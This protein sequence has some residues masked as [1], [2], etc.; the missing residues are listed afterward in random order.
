MESLKMPI[1]ASLKKAL[2]HSKNTF[3]WTVKAPDGAETADSPAFVSA[4]QKEQFAAVELVRDV[5]G[6]T[7]SLRDKAKSYLPQFPREADG[8]WEDRR[9]TSVVYN[10]LKR[11]VRGL[12]GMVFRRD[13]V[14]GDDVPE[15]IREHLEDIDLQGRALHVFARDVFEDAMID[16]HAFVFIDWNATPE[17]EF[18]TRAEER[19]FGSRPYWG[20]VRKTDLLSFRR[21]VID[22]RP[23][24]TQAAWREDAIEAEGRFGETCVP[25]IRVN[26]LVATDAGR[27]VEWENWRREKDTWVMDQSGVLTLDEIPLI[28]LYVNRVDYLVSEPPLL[29]LAYENILHWQTRSDRQNTLHIAGVP[30][31]IFVGLSDNDASVTVGSTMGVRLPEGGE[32][33]YLEPKGVALQ[34]SREEIHDIERRMAMLGLSML[35]SD[36]RAAETATSKRIDK[37]ESDSQLAAAARGLEDALEECLRIHAKWMGLEQ[38]GSVAV[39]ADFV[40]TPMDPQ[41]ADTLSRLV[42]SGQLS[43]ETMWQALVRGEILPDSFDPDLERVRIEDLGSIERLLGSGN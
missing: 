34:E 24:L 40:D 11:T 10:A 2:E 28:P 8:S 7:P 20:L 14:I 26:R 23:I 19:A 5:F 1:S 18:R 32:A 36:T 29:D 41:L 16:G 27:R 15:E 37:S 6:G 22:G 21:E 39:N 35:M 9:K 31:P 3:T 25:R 30:V 42:M 17:R 38:G 33:F 4:S 43:M 12:T 13:P